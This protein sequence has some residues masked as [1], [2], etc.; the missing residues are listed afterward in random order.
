MNNRVLTYAEAIREGIKEEMLKDN[1]VFLMGEDIRINIWGVT[2]G[3]VDEFGDERVLHMPISENGFCATAV[4]AAVAGM[5]PVVEICFCDF[6]LLAADA[7]CNIASKYRYMSGGQFSVPVTYRIAGSGTGTGGAHHSQSLEAIPI[8]FPGLKVVY[9]STPYDAKGLIKT[10]IADDDPVIFFEHKLLYSEKGQVPQEEYFIPFGDGIVR[11]QGK[12]LSIVSYGKIIRIVQEI[13]EEL[14]KEKGIDIEV[15]D[16]RTLRPFDYEKLLKS[17]EKTG[18]LII[19]EEDTLI[20]GVGAEIAA[21]IC[22]I[23]LFHIDAPIKRIAAR[24]TP[25]PAGKYGHTFVV[26]CKEHI[27]TEVVNF[28]SEV[29]AE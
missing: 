11:R 1:H 19:V 28:L 25:I 17:I 22:G 15:Y 7:I 29:S 2:R 3:L 24:E 23:G 12:D 27:K 14:Y 21:T 6:I 16:P 5:R 18:K 10:A 4:G 26:P 8:H 20:G 9:A 13:A